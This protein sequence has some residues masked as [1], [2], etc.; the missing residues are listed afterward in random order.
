SN[1]IISDLDNLLGVATLGSLAAGASTGTLT[2]QLTLPDINDSFWTANGG[3]GTYTIGMI[4][5]SGNAVAEV[6]E[7]NNSNQGDLVDFDILTINETIAADLVATSANVVLEPQQ[8]G[9]TFD[10]EFDISNLGGAATGSYDVS[11]YLS[12]NDIISDLDNLLGVATLSSLAAGASTGTLVTQLTLPDIND[13]F[14]TANGGNGTYSIGMIIDSGNAVAEI[15]ESNNSN[16]GDLI[17]FDTLTINE[18]IAADLVGAS[19]NV[20][21]EPLTAGAT[22]DF[23]YTLSN[24]GGASTG[25]PFNVQFYL[26]N[27]STISAADFL[28][29]EA[30]IS[31]LAAGTTT[32]TLTQQLLLPSAGDPFWIGDGTYTIGMIV[33]ADGVIAEV[34]ELNNSNRGDLIDRDAVQITGT[35]QADLV[36]TLSNVVIEPQ[37]AGSTFT[38]EFDIS[39]IGGLASGAFDVDFYLSTNDIISTNDEL[40]GSVTVSSVAANTAT[41]ILSVNLTLPGINDTF[42]QGNGTY[43]VGTIIDPANTVSETNEAN[44]LNVGLFEDFDNVIV[45]D[46]TQTGTRNND[47]FIGTDAADSF[48]GL[49]GDD[50]VFGGAGNDTLD[51]GRGDDDVFGGEGDDLVLGGFGDDFVAGGSGND[52]VVGNRGDD[53]IV[54]VD[55]NN[56][57]NPGADQ[58][59][60]LTGGFGDD[61]FFLGDEVQSYYVD[62][63]T[64]DYAV[65]TDFTAGEDVIALH[66]SASDYTLGTPASGLPFGTGVFQGNE[67]VGII[68]GDTAGLSL[69]SANFVYL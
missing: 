58:I 30:T 1:T 53:L 24:L 36:S 44:N 28:L 15:D 11:F 12:S 42:W 34:D 45:N 62:T 48:D 63:T 68:Q 65:I 6:N 2:T 56:T 43:Y 14:W 39:N 61:A 69:T 41:G 5:D 4:I 66:G 40:L 46:V 16:Q 3:N 32:S 25:Q 17:D 8:A 55:I 22:F 33:D 31:S 50:D 37:T 20:V 52:E 27:N 59:D 26:S 51:G 64:P 29:G 18:T 54:G 13:A 49:R 38:Y 23:D 60:T 7:S 9:N 19:A 10:F 57:V 21:V 47:D 35:Q 67:L